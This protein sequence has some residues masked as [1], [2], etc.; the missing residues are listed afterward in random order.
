MAQQIMNVKLNQEQEYFICGTD[1]GFRIFHMDPLQQIAHVGEAKVGSI[2]CVEM[3]SR[4]NVVAFVGGGAR[5]KYDDHTVVVWDLQKQEAS[6]KVVVKEPVLNIKMIKDRLMVVLRSRI[7][8]LSLPDGNTLA[9]IPT[10]DNPLGVCAVSYAARKMVFP[11]KKNRGYIQIE[12]VDRADCGTEST[13][14]VIVKAHGNDVVCAA[15]SH[16]GDLVATASVQGTNIHVYNSVSKELS[17]FRRG[18]DKANIYCL[19]FS[20]DSSLLCCSSDKGTVHIWSL[21]DVE[22]NPVSVIKPLVGLPMEVKSYASFTVTAECPCV[23][24]IAGEAIYAI[25][26]DGSFQKYKLARNGSQ[27]DTGINCV[28]VSYDIYPNVG[29]LY[30][31]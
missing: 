16:G 21:K 26:L 28:R 3:R 2:R 14:P 6:M 24:A 13:P 20:K 11:S 25:C 1:N 29:E 30:D 4:S 9:D 17:K 31:C 15:V 8:V 19:N 10:R 22:L 7:I 12:D 18:V 23:C 5:P 27:T